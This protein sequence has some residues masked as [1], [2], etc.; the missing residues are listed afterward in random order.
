M[1]LSALTPYVRKAMDHTAPAGWHLRERVLFDYELL[2]VKEGRVLVTVRDRAYEGVPGDLFLF[3]PREPHSLRVGTESPFRQPHIHFDLYERPDSPDVKISFKPE[4][5]M[6]AQ[7]HEWFREDVL[8]APPFMVPNHI[9]PVGKSAVEALVFAMIDEYERKLPYYETNLK[10]LFVQLWTLLLRE[11]HWQER[12]HVL[13]NWETLQ[14]VKL[15]M[16]RSLDREL[17]VDELAA[18]A[19]MSKY[20]FIRAFKSA[21]GAPPIKYHLTMRIEKAKELIQFTSMPVTEIAARLG[22][23]SIHAFSRAFRHAEGVAPTYYRG[24]KGE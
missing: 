6:T 11:L 5:E 19:N 22:F 17:T 16:S 8:S 24:K 3:K 9:R 1:D 20:Y 7:E 18:A 23:P 2:Y 14:A 10:G 12:P 21:F 4:H 15:L 13:S